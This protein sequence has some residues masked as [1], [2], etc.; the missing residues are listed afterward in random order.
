[1]IK[2]PKQLQIISDDNLI[3]YV[4]TIKTKSD[5]TF[6]YRYIKSATKVNNVTF[7]EEVLRKFIANETFVEVAEKIISEN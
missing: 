2:P 4:R 5:T 6:E 7:S 3:E 1:M